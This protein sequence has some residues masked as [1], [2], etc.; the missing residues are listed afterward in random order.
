MSKEIRGVDDWEEPN[1][2]TAL[3]FSKIASVSGIFLRLCFLHLLGAVSHSIENAV[4]GTLR[5]H[6]VDASL[7]NFLANRFCGDASKSKRRLKL[8][9]CL[10]LRFGEKPDG[11]SQ[12]GRLF[13]GSLSPSGVNIVEASNS[14]AQ[15]T[16]ARRNSRSTLSEVLFGFTGTAI[17]K[18]DG[19]FCL[20]LATLP[21][22]ELC[23]RQ[24]DRINNRILLTRWHE[25]PC[26]HVEPSPVGSKSKSHSPSVD[27]LWR[28]A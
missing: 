26:S 27:Q 17:T 18:F 10:R 23:G 22:S 7:C 4:H 11:I 3:R 15:L 2:W 12:L 24:L 5:R 1:P 19:N 28:P 16:Q 8:G 14:D 21:A 6:V 9:I 20:V 13:F 25:N